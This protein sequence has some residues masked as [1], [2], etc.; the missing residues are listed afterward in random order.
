MK[1]SKTLN[2][3]GMCVSFLLIAFEIVGAYF[4]AN[5]PIEIGG[6]AVMTFS[7]DSLKFYTFLTCVITLLGSSLMIWSNIVSVIKK[8]DCTPRLF[9]SIRFL[10]AVMSLLTFVTAVAFLR[11]AY[12]ETFD[13]L[14]GL[15]GGCIFL[16]FICPILSMLQFAFLEIEPKAKFSKTLEPFIATLI[17]ALAILVVVLVKSKNDPDAAARW[18][19]YFFFWIT[20]DLVEKGNA[21]YKMS[22]TIGA[23]I[24]IA[25]GIIVISYAVSVIVWGI[26]RINHAIVVGDV[27]QLPILN[28]AKAAP[29]SKASTSA[30]TKGKK[31]GGKTAS[32]AAP[33]PTPAPTPV[34]KGNSFTRYVKAK[35][36]FGSSDTPTSG[37]IYHVS[38]HDRRLQTWKVKAEGSARALKVFPSQK[39]AI[40]F[41]TEQV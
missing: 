24:G 34:K 2:L 30:K 18:A 8:K 1:R 4:L 22:T 14:F 37:Q 13:A 19:P 35:V 36:A 9:Y 3:I 6:E 28:K 12:I 26:N 32:K 25:V 20:P 7:V 15:E 10:S 27:Y 5:K 11:P 21:A 39:E 16:H 38:Y 33:A 23:N 41:A 29:A 40:A 17:Y 31:K